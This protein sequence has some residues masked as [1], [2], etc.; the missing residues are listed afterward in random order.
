M[1]PDIDTVIVAYNNQSTIID[2]I[3]SVKGASS[4]KIVVV[5]HGQDSTFEVADRHGALAVHN[6]DNPGFGAGI[7]RGF[8]ETTSKY[9]LLLNPDA[10][11]EPDALPLGVVHL[12][13]HPRVAALQGIVISTVT[14]E[15][16]RSQGVEVGPVHLIGRASG[17]KILLKSRLGQRLARVLPT[18]SDHADRVPVG[19]ATVDT[20][21][22]TAIL[23]RR[24]SLEEISGFDPRY[25]LY[26]EDL[27][28]CRRFR[29]AG[30]ELAALPIPWATHISG[31]SMGDW[32]HR[33]YQW[34]RGTMRF[35]AQWYSI[36]SFVLAL[37][38]S[39]IMSVRIL[40]HGSKG[41]NKVI[42]HL[43][44]DPVR[45]RLRGLNSR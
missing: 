38:A 22:A 39:S 15:P 40:V 1:L 44:V 4:G 11:L 7:N 16:E 42:M 45:F 10:R 41:L 43:V 17:A 18:T 25:F 37:V 2:A 30:W 21:A 3:R 32:A 19:P 29:N 13:Q 14:G 8:G 33:E 28:L 34:W 6:P 24:E 12:E 26:G 23:V 31:A 27:D 36:P 20:L 35:A 5:D 9:V